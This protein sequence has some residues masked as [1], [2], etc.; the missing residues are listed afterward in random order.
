[1]KKG[2]TKRKKLSPKAP[3]LTLNGNFIKSDT[4]RVFRI[5]S[6]F[7]EG[8]EGLSKIG[9]AVSFFGSKSTSPKHKYYKL[10]VDSAHM[11]AKHGYSIITGAGQGIMEAANKGA[12]EAGGLSVGLNILI[13]EEQQPNPYINH[14][15]EF[16][17]FFIRKVMFTKYS[18]AM[19]V[20][21]G[22][23]GTLDEFFESIALIQTDR[24]NPIPVILVGKDYW[25]GL[26]DWMKN[27]MVKQGTIERKDLKLFSTADTPAQ[28]LKTID[29][30][31]KNK[32]TRKK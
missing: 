2:K 31:Y 19:V 4:W 6:E 21:P 24:I 26:L 3:N 11:L 18:W 17:Y 25:K 27:V 8:F 23:L 28:I 5:M 16:R 9:K 32:P 7:V 14:L 12:F 15:V 1:M 22:G 13:P 30:F 20:F 29:S 10:A